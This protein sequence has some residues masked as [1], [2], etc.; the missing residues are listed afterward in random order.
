MGNY[1]RRVAHKAKRERMLGTICCNC[2]KECG[3]DIEYHHVVPLERGGFDII[4]NLKPLCFECHAK[5]HFDYERKKPERTGRKR[6]AYDKDLLDSV[7]GRYVSGEIMELDARKE[8]GTGC[9]IRDMIQFKEWAEEH[10]IDLEH[11]HF[12]RGGPK[13]T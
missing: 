1:S 6:K 13:H 11:A 2:G 7:F 3:A 10:G 5:V 4:S 9:R 12:G 8:L